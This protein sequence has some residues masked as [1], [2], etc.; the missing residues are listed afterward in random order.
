MFSSFK[1]LFTTT[2]TT[3]NS[4]GKDI[5][6][7]N[8]E[9]IIDKDNEENKEKEKEKMIFKLSMEIYKEEDPTQTLYEISLFNQTKIYDSFYGEKIKNWK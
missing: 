9:N 1:N 3:E 5:N 4:L 6:Q 2:K 8:S 7:Y